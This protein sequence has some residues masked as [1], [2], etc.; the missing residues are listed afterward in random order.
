[1]YVTSFFFTFLRAER[2]IL[3]D[4]I[5]RSNRHSVDQILNQTR[6][7]ATLRLKNLPRLYQN[8]LLY[9]FY[10]CLAIELNINTS[11]IAT[12]DHHIAS[13][14]PL[15]LNL[16]SVHSFGPPVK[17]VDHVIDQKTKKK[18]KKHR[19]E[20]KATTSCIILL[21]NNAATVTSP[22]RVLSRFVSLRTR[23]RALGISRAPST[24]LARLLPCGLKRPSTETR[25][26][27]L[28][29]ATAACNRERQREEAARRTM[30]RAGGCEIC[31]SQD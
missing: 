7:F 15:F 31:Q 3:I 16:K 30:G 21:N 9:R 25:D 18:K 13:L 11:A 12:L 23:Q 24:S 10:A 14:P 22:A 29:G 2:F 27:G 20:K 1:M 5:S 28:S 17:S 26:D 8:S 19:K 6:R 4:Q